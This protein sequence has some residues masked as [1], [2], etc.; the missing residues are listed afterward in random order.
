MNIAMRCAVLSLGLA[1]C[2]DLN[3]LQSGANPP[4][5][6]L[7][8]D[9][10]DPQMDMAQPPAD[11]A[12]PDM[13]NPD[14]ASP[15]AWTNVTPATAPGKLNAISGFVGGGITT[16]YAV[17]AAATVLKS[18]NGA[19]FAPAASPAMGAMEF[20]ALFIRDASNLW[21]ADANGK[22][23][24]ST[25]AAATTANWTDKMTG[26][27]IPQ[28]GIFGRAGADSVL[29]AG[30]DTTRGLF[31]NPSSGTAWSATVSACTGGVKTTGVWGS[32]GYYLF[33]G[34]GLKAAK[35]PNPAMACNSLSNMDLV[36][37]ANFVAASGV[38]DQNAFLL[39]ADGQL[40]HSDLT[41]ANDKMFRRGRVMNATF[42]ALW[43]RNQNEVWV[44]G[45]L[46]GSP[47]VWQWVT[48]S[49]NM[50]DRTGN[51]SAAGYTLSG[52]WG[53]S[54]GSLWIIGNNGGTGAIFKH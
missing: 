31:L 24:T 5:M 13:S 52:I 23:F 48:G 21:V 10:A 45:S 41:A 30:D 42:T 35:G 19:A 32:A 29:V 1:G 4:D 40:G 6:A 44:V 33:V 7:P 11:M 16:V 17:G 27:A 37:S 36:G 8:V 47:K 3:A 46:A 20:T 39:T 51:L 15:F 26:S 2:L 34:E 53:D 18:A 54:A 49:L 28:R 9:M 14:M 43:V 38:D 50:T 25:D 22:V 12:T